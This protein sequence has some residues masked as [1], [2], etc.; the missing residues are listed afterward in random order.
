MTDRPQSEDRPEDRAKAV[1]H[2][3][4][5][6]ADALAWERLSP[7]HRK[8]D[9]VALAA[10]G[11]VGLGLLKLLSGHLQTVSGLHSLPS[12][13]LLLVS[14]G[15]GVWLL[16]RR[17]QR[18]RAA[19]RVGTQIR[20]RLELWPERL[21]EHR[22]DRRKPLVVGGRSLRMLEETKDHVFLA[23]GREDVVIVPARAF[24]TPAAKAD[25]AAYW[26]AKID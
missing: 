16:Q 22:A 12:A 6:V 13:I 21:I 26:R 11:F 14:P 7:A 3:A 23:A 24:A 19:L 8:R 25:F 5:D 9:R 2:Y 18:K 20:T 15:L 10:S 4:L 17:D 1:L